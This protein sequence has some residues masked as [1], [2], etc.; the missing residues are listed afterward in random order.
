MKHFVFENTWMIKQNNVGSFITQCFYFLINIK[1]NLFFPIAK[2]NSVPFLLLLTEIL[3]N[4]Q[5][6]TRLVLLFLGL[7]VCYERNLIQGSWNQFKTTR[8]WLITHCFYYLLK[9]TLKCNIGLITYKCPLSLNKMYF[10]KMG[11]IFFSCMLYLFIPNKN[12]PILLFR[13][14]SR[15]YRKNTNILEFFFHLIFTDLRLIM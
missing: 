9:T 12:R 8:Q 11:Y 13:Y 7:F 2:K 10:I 1:S 3:D 14:T 6:T 4:V 15:Q 5:F